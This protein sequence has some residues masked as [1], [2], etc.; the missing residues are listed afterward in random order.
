MIQLQD[1][2]SLIPVTKFTAH[3]TYIT[4]VLLSPDS[5]QLATC[6][7]DHTARIWTV[8]PVDA[9]SPAQI[10]P[11]Q[12]EENAI[13]NGRDQSDE[14]NVSNDDESDE[15]DDDDDEDDD[16]D[17]DDDDSSSL[18]DRSS[19]P[20]S[21]GTRRHA[22]PS[23]HLT[24]GRQ[25]QAQSRQTQNR[26][27]QQQQHAALK[28]ELPMR[29]LVT[30][31]TNAPLDTITS[32]ALQH[33]HAANPATGVPAGP[34]PPPA[35]PGVSRTNNAIIT[36]QDVHNKD[37]NRRLTAPTGPTPGT[38]PLNAPNAFPLQTTLHGHQRWVWDC[39]FSADSAYL[40]TACSDH[41]ARLWELSTQTV[42][43]Q[44]NGH[45]RGAVCVA[46]NDFSNM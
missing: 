1:A 8:L 3:N 40:V 11:P 39:A 27:P 38:R 18:S 17:I 5:K 28:S 25:L 9:Q 26:P 7:A 29:A 33:T 4:R 13:E 41:Y 32:T 37:P 36:A 20:L 45:H 46:L 44:Y 43:R 19:P 22:P 2:T 31:S 16:E 23:P 35:A 34:P 6:S 10:E 21:P 15:L 24:R 30:G 14:D 12:E 42:I